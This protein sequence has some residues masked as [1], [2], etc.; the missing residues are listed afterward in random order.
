MPRQLLVGCDDPASLRARLAQAQVQLNALAEQLFADPRFTPPQQPARFTLE[1][2]CVGALGH[3]EGVTFD[4]IARSAA[5]RGLATC[6]LVLAPWLRLLWLAQP[7]A[8]ADDAP[9]RHRAP[10][11]ACTVTSLPPPDEPDLPWGFYLW[12]I[13]G[14]AWLRGYRCW[15]GHVWA[16]EDWLVF[17]RIDPTGCQGP[18]PPPSTLL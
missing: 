1:A 9:G 12:R 16:R 3:A 4:A 6:P 15:A 13:E 8:P 14:V 10:V 5:A 7:A 17:Q 11:G 2:V 18:A